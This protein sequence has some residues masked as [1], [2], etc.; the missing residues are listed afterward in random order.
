MEFLTALLIGFAGSF[1]CVG[2]CGPI[3]LALPVSGYTKKNFIPGRLLYNLGRIVSYSFMGAF[4]GLLG[5]RVMVAGLQQGLSIFLGAFI[6]LILIVP[7]RYKNI[8]LAVPVI[9]KIISLLKTAIG[10]QFKSRGM[11]ALFVTG[12]L[13]GFLPCGFVYIGLAAAASAGTLIKGAGVMAMFGLGTAPV[14]IAVSSFGRIINIDFRRR[15][16]RAVPYFAAVLAVI[17]ILRG[18]SLGIPYLSP[19]LGTIVHNSD[20]CH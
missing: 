16:S 19:R 11:S 7:A 4:F 14:L 13:N 20:C 10:R 6:L 12:V 18:M 1:H 2:M 9:Q 5:G 15:L 3:A 17:F 8:L